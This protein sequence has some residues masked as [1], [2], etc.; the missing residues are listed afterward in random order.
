MGTL[1]RRDWIRLIGGAA[2]LA[3]LPACT[4]KPGLGL[5]DDERAML[6]KLADVVIPP[7]DQPG[8]AALGTVEY[9]DRL[10]L[11]LNYTTPR[12]YAGGPFSDRA[13]GAENDFASFIDLDRVNYAAWQTYLPALHDQLKQGLAAARAM[14]VK[15]PQALFDALDPD[16]KDLLIDLV[17]EAAFAAPEYG[18]N[19]GLRGWQMIHFEGDSLPNGYSAEQVSQ[20]TASDPEPLTADVKQILAAVV[21]FL[22]GRV[23]P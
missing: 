15:D 4:N 22:G 2:A 21:Q 5:T 10:I 23:K 9:T 6:A 8:G 13:G 16:F 18:G 1:S 19:P 12:V 17:S 11:A 7:D 3:K 20:P 14:N